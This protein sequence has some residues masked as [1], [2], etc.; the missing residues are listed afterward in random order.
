HGGADVRTGNEQT[1]DVSYA[2]DDHYEHG[3]DQRELDGRDAFLAGPSIGNLARHAV[4]R[5]REETVHRTILT[6]TLLTELP[7]G[8][9]KT[10]LE[11]PVV[12]PVKV[13]LVAI[14][15]KQAPV[16]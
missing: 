3:G 4:A 11:A 8:S 6:E 13:T 10:Q 7:L 12:P 14:T 9:V 16:P 5:R 1:P 2:C 15:W